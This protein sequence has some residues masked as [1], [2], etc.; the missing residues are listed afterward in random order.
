MFSCRHPAWGGGGT[1]N[2]DHHGAPICFCDT[3]FASRDALGH[4]SCVP[5]RVLVAGYLVLAA[6]SLLTLV[7]LGRHLAEY[8]HI[9]DEARLSRKTKIRLSVL[10]FGRYYFPMRQ[11][12][13]CL[14]LCECI[15]LRLVVTHSV[16]PAP[17]NA[18]LQ[19]AEEICFFLN[20]RCGE[21]C[22]VVR[23]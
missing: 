2:T 16:V 10:L 5:Y 8:R 11:A 23:P 15:T 13:L 3:V 19:A 4:A 22:Q 7:V 18:A 17:T 1:C 12:T 14:M 21:E 9:S 20:L 6:L